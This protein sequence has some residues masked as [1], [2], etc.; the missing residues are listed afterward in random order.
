MPNSTLSGFSA[1]LLIF[2]SVFA[3]AACL[4]APASMSIFFLSEIIS[5]PLIGQNY[6]CYIV[7][8][9]IELEEVDVG[10]I[11]AAAGKEDKLN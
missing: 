9:V 4:A 5:R 8:E 10:N 6:E 3:G 11:S 1:L 7:I 2:A